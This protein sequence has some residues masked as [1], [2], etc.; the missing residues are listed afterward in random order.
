MRTSLFFS[1]WCGPSHGCVACARHCAVAR[2]DPPHVAQ[3]DL[4][5][6]LS[7]RAT[8]AAG[9]TLGCSIRQCWPMWRIRP[10]GGIPDTVRELG[11][12]W[13][14]DGVPGV[15][16]RSASGL[17]SRA[18]RCS[19]C[20][21]RRTD[22]VETRMGVGSI[23]STRRRVDEACR[24]GGAG[25][26]RVARIGRATAL[27][28]AAEGATSRSAISTTTQGRG[29]RQRDPRAGPA[30]DDRSLDVVD[31]AAAARSPTRRPTR[32][33]RSTSCSTTPA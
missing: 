31:I 4:L 27:A 18:A 16:P 10:A 6:H 23:G 1:R 17:R 30:R 20:G 14:R 9:A 15:F 22:G 7:L 28:F 29:N 2:R 11:A 19:C 25:D 5:T 13:V 3:G 12:V 26:R 32:S 24:T 21:R 8:G 33:D